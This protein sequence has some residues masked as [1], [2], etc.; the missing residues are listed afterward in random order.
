MTLTKEQIKAAADFTKKVA[1]YA[2]SKDQTVAQLKAVYCKESV[3]SKPGALCAPCVIGKY[4]TDKTCKIP[5]CG[6]DQDFTVLK[7]CGVKASSNTMAIVGGVI[8]GLVVIGLLVYFFGMKNEDDKGE[9]SL[10]D[11]F[12][13]I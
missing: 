12:Q 6:K 13:Q 8:A 3:S 4:D 10:L 5:E 1:A 11:D 7:P 2:T 9:A